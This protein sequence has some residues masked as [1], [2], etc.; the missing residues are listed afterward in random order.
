MNL[1]ITRWAIRHGVDRLAL[2]ELEAI[3]GMHGGHFVP[4]D[5]KGVSEAAMQAAVRR[6]AAQC[7]ARLFRNNV[8][9]LLDKRGVPVRYGLANDTA[10]LN[11][12][13]KSADLIGWRPVLIRPE[14]VGTTIAQFLSREVKAP[15]WVYRGDAHEQAQLAWANLVLAGGGDAAFCTGVGTVD[16]NVNK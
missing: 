5:I 4:P 1:A 8:G 7:G 16:T 13:V 10:A 3:M 15:G 11:A 2:D 6:E 9:A 12:V 14:H